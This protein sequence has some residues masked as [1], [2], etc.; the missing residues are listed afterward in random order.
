MMKAF[1]WFLIAVPFVAIT[2]MMVSELGLA[3]AAAV[4]GIVVLMGLTMFAGMALVDRAD[5]L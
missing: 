2:L 4:V 3:G 1:G 5:G